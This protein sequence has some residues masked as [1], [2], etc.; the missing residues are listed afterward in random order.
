MI[1]QRQRFIALVNAYLEKHKEHIIDLARQANVPVRTLYPLLQDRE[2]RESSLD[3]YRK[4]ARA[5][6]IDFG[7]LRA[8][9]ENEL[10]PHISARK[11]IELTSDKALP[12]GYVLNILYGE[13]SEEITLEQWLTWIEVSQLPQ[14]RREFIHGLIR[15]ILEQG[16]NIIDDSK[17]RGGE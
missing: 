12:S 17:P 16:N 7:I 13:I 3:T 2:D 8:Y 1:E 4:L 14:D 9:L 15:M 11:V 10:A 5:M 6:G